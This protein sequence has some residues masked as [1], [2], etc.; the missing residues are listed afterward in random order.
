MFGVEQPLVDRCKNFDRK[1]QQLQQMSENIQQAA[2]MPYLEK[3]VKAFQ[4]RV[5]GII[6]GKLS[7]SGVKAIH[8]D[9]KAVLGRVQLK[10]AYKN[11]AAKLSLVVPPGL[12]EGFYKRIWSLDRGW[13][14]A[15]GKTKAR[16]IFTLTRAE[17]QS[18]GQ[19][20]MNLATTYMEQEK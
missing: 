11:H 19:Q 10:L 12:G 1:V 17:K 2:L 18:I 15:E 7:A 3:A 8:G 20:I 14:T 9:L 13:K 6:L 4:P 16:D 5:I